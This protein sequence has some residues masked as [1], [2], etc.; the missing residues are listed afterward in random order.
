MVSVRPLAFRFAYPGLNRHNALRL[1][2]LSRING[3]APRAQND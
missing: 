1:I 3:D 2:L